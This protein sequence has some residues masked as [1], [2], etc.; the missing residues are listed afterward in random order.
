MNLYKTISSFGLVV[1]FSSLFIMTCTLLISFPFASSFSIV[2]QAIA[3]VT[4]IVIAAFFKIG[5]VVYIVGRYERGLA[6]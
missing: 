3:H 6:V 2:E 4:T 5:Y 1:M